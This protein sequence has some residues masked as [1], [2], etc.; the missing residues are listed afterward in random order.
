[1]DSGLVTLFLCGDVM[2][3]R[4]VDQILPHPGR[5]QLQEQYVLDARDYVR[6]AERAHGPVPRP[7]SFAWPWGDALDILGQMAPTARLVNLETSITHSTDFAPGK[8]VHYRMSPQN[9]PALAAARPDAIALANNHVLDFGRTGLLDTL[10]TLASAGLRTAGAGRDATQ[11]LQP[12]V[13]PARYATLTAALTLLVGRC[14]WRRGC[15]GWAS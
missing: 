13:I 4:G 14:R 12:A 7:A 3:G 2:L 8:G 1:V 10:A 5:P 9:L 6:L 15:C 11:A